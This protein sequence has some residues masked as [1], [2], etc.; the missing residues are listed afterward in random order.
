MHISINTTVS[1]LSFIKVLLH[2]MWHRPDASL[3]ASASNKDDSNSP[4][5]QLFLPVNFKESKQ[6][7][8]VI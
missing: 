4:S 3:A 5:P 8:V 6:N 7:T 2:R 1:H